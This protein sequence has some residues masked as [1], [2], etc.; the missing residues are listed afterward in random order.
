MSHVDNSKS[1]IDDLSIA[2]RQ[3]EQSRNRTTLG[4]ED[5]LNLMI[6]QM[7]NQ[8]PMK[9]MEN[10][11][12]IGQMAQFSSVSGLND[13]KNSF[14]ELN[15]ALISNQALQASSMVGRFV[16][17]PS[18]QGYLPEGEGERFFGAVDLESSTSNLNINI[19]A[20]SGEL[21]KTIALGSQP[22]G[23]KRFSWDGT[24]S[25]GEMMPAG[26]YELT[27]TVYRD[28]EDVGVQTMFLAPVES[29]SLGNG[30][31]GMRLNVS[32]LGSMSM[33]QVKEI[34]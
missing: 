3:A 1:L 23:L 13:I 8:D 24:N 4:Q 14:S 26:D 16:M 28:G 15:N 9:P 25:A 10:G 31:K 34:I 33:D 18:H 22:E 32:G 2:Q 30:G 29:V 17:V 11:E 6:T 27:A 21:I 12:F 7:K 5:F 19:R 20:K